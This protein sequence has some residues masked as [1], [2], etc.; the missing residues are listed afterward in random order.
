MRNTTTDPVA[1][2][3]GWIWLPDASGQAQTTLQFRKEFIWQPDMGDAARLLIS[4]SHIYRVLLNGQPVGRGPDRADPRRPYYDVYDI[5]GLLQPGQNVLCGLAHHF[6]PQPGIRSSLYDGA[7][8]LLAQLEA[9]GRAI[10]ATDASWRVRPSPGWRDC[11]QPINRFRP[12]RHEFDMAGLA[13]LQAAPAAGYDDAHWMAAAA[14]PF[15]PDGPLPPPVPREIPFL[16]PVLHEPVGVEITQAGLDIVNGF[17]ELRGRP[18]NTPMRINPAP[19]GAWIF[20]DYGRVMGGFP[21]LELAAEGA[22]VLDIYCGE[23]DTWLLTD[24]LRLAPAGQG[25]YEPLDWRGGQGLGLHFHGLTAPVAVLS[26]R[27]KE[28]VYPFETRGMFRCSDDTLTSVWK[29]S[30]ETAWSG[31]KDHPVDC[32]NR[33][34]ALW[35]A[36]VVVHSRALA[37]CFGDMRPSIKTMRQA[38]SIMTNDGIVPVPGPAGLGYKLDGPVLNWAEMTLSLFPI[39]AAIDRHAPDNDL[40]A[41]CLPRLAKILAHFHR[42]RNDAGLLDTL[43]PGLP[44]IKC[45]GGWNPMLKTGV[46]CAFNSEYVLALRAGAQL[47]RAAHDPAQAGAW[48]ALADTSAAAIRETFW[49]ESRGLFADGLRDGKLLEQFSPTAN[50]WAALAGAL[51]PDRAGAWA[52]SVRS[53]PDIMPPQTPFDA[54]LLLEAF[55]QCGLELQARELLDRYWGAIIRAG[56][57]TLP[58]FWHTGYRDGLQFRTTSSSLCHPF[59]AGPAYLLPEYILGV[60]TAAPGWRKAIIQPLAM[61]LQWAQGRIPTPAGAIEIGWEKSDARWELEV[62]LPPGMSAEL[63]LPRLSWGRERLLINRRE[64]WR[65]EARDDYQRQLDRNYIPAGPREVRAPLNAPGRHLIVLESF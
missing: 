30:R 23:G 20:L 7:P 54:T 34:Q 27:F 45:F 36:D 15:A 60:Q 18:E 3:A 14:F 52:E 19:E 55:L 2:Q 47:A 12:C 48:D 50:A 46:T 64:A 25:C 28:M 6:R 59:G 37:A 32:L 10:I 44:E 51:L 9:G 56:H 57:T 5:A 17:R 21:L 16:V 33:E 31:V 49:V 63:V 42:Y 26:A 43:K 38:L 65:A 13:D 40:L 4:A 1:W 58:E 8:G 24:R 62:F 11:S 61:G 29:V 41:W 39:A 35:L 53:A 22:G